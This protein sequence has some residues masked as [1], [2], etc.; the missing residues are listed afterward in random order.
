MVQAAVIERLKGSVGNIM[1]ATI[2]STLRTTLSRGLASPI[3]S[4]WR[5][6]GFDASARDTNGAGPSRWADEARHPV[7]RNSLVPIVV[8]QTVS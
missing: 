2:R 5:G 1:S 4:Q 7:V 3:L 6:F 8:E